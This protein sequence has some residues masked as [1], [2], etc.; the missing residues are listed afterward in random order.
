MSPT[1]LMFDRTLRTRLDLLFPNT[2]ADQVG[3]SQARMIA[4]H[5]N[6]QV[7]SFKPGYLVYCG[8]FSTNQPKWIP[9]EVQ[10]TTGPLSYR[11]SLSSMVVL[12]EDMWIMSFLVKQNALLILLVK[13]ISSFHLKLNQK[14]LFHKTIGLSILGRSCLDEW[15][16]SLQI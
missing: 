5:K 9:A 14:Q 4:K 1:F 12:S 2:A 6:R 11:L 7:P 15:P 3:N 13:M 10:A 8:N 16:A